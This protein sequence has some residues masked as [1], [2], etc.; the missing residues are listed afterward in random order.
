MW[1]LHHEGMWVVSTTSCLP[2]GERSQTP[3]SEVMQGCFVSTI[4]LC[5]CP[6]PDT[7]EGKD[8]Q[9]S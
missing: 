3:E 7:S 8:S 5:G 4:I 1:A 9:H 2:V 6:S